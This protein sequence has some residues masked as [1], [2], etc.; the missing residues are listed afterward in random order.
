MICEP[1]TLAI[2]EAEIEL[3]NGYTLADFIF[4]EYDR[5]EYKDHSIRCVL[6][7]PDGLER[8]D[9][10][11]LKVLYDVHMRFK[12]TDYKLAFIDLHWELPEGVWE[13]AEDKLTELA[14]TFEMCADLGQAIQAAKSKS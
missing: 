4:Q 8:E 10:E 14:Q 9:G 3:P 13:A 5:D 1:K 2:I 11:L 7:T 6:I 12:N